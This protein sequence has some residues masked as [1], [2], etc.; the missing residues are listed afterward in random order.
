MSAVSR[1][2]RLSV[3]DI[4]ARKGGDPLVCLTAYTAP[5]ALI[6]D[7]RMDVLLV[8]DSLGM[9]VYGMDDTLAVSLDMMIAH[10]RAVVRATKASFVLVDLPFGSYEESPA[11]AFRSA[12]RLM[13]ESGCQAVK[14]EG[15]VEMAETI[16]FLTARG[17]PVMGHIGLMP[18]S[19]HATG[20]F[21]A[22]GLSQ[23]EA[24]R[25]AADA[26]AVAEAGAFAVVIEGTSE[27]LARRL[28]ERLSIPT[29]GIGA[30][31][32]CD[33]QILVTDDLLG[34]FSDFTPKFVKRYAEIGD[35][36][37]AAA[38]AYAEDVRM[39]DFPSLAHCY[40]VPK[41]R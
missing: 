2:K 12:S 29:I 26:D 34:L 21:R 4:R 30:S 6:L 28:T 31:P 9:V 16:A 39:R 20:G 11:Q 27:P 7:E 24:E 32:A 25:I 40:G 41:D 35:A 14:L 10:G 23:H 18:Q 3:T 5:V 19:V 22:Q 36:I 8:G 38:D 1:K 15:G 33:G 13:A 37:A 17:V